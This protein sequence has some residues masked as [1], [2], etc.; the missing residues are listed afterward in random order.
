MWITADV[1]Y[2][3]QMANIANLH[4]Y[5]VCVCFLGIIWDEETLNTYLQNPKKYIPGT[6]MVFSG[7]RKKREREDII[8][9]LKDAT[10]E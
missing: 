6:K 8:A 10:S 9:Y 2:T 1:S 7:L 4:V 5:N 3:L